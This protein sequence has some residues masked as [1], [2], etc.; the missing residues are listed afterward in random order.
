MPHSLYR[1]GPGV[2]PC[3]GGLEGPSSRGW[4]GYAKQTRCLGS[5]PL[6]SML[7]SICFA[8]VPRP[9]R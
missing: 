4:A 2:A 9:M 5:Q 3:V 6:S 8:P 1:P 7:R